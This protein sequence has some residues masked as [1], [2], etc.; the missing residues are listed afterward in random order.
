MTVSTFVVVLIIV[1]SLAL[2]LFF[3]AYDLGRAKERNEYEN[4]KEKTLLQVR[5][6]RNSLDDPD[7]VERLHNAFKR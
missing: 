2:V 4:Q 6:L 3:T 5:Q 1:L 7:V